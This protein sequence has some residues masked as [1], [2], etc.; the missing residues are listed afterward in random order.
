MKKG[1]PDRQ[2]KQ[3]LSAVTEDEKSVMAPRNLET[4]KNHAISNVLAPG[5]LPKLVKLLV[6]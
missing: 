3:T 1:I 6:K 2:S 4:I 5:V